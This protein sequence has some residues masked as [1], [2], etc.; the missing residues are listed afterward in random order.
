VCASAASAGPAVPAA[1]VS[2][3]L[4]AA[5]ALA[6]PVQVA[7]VSCIANPSDVQRRATMTY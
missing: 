6:Q 2:E 5:V 4:L 3:E 7:E 1:Q